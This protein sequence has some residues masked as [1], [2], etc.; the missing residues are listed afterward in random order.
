MNMDSNFINLYRFYINEKK[1]WFPY[2]TQGR[3]CKMP[4]QATIDPCNKNVEQALCYIKPI[5]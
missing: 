3:I 4:N 2:P 1:K 5:L